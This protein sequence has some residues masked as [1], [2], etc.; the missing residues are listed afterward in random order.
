[1][2]LEKL[3]LDASG[4]ETRFTYWMFGVLPAF[5]ISIAIGIASAVFS[6]LLLLLLLAAL[7]PLYAITVKRLHD[8]DKSALWILLYLGLAIMPYILLAIFVAFA[9][10][11]ENAYGDSDFLELLAAPL[12]FGGNL[13]SLVVLS[14]AL[15][16]LGCLEGTPGENRYG[17]A[18]KTPELSSASVPSPQSTCPNCHRV[19]ERMAAQ[20]PNC[21]YHISRRQMKICPY[22]GE[23]I[24]SPAVICRYCNSNLRN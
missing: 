20:C 4:R 13:G 2:D 11:V 7:A 19:I 21:N 16:D 9:I 8:R 24:L 14:W 23:E 3:Y 17:P 1:M 10:I 15:V 22:C 12:V 6:H 18:L 5:G